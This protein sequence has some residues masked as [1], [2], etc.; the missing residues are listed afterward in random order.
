MHINAKTLIDRWERNISKHSVED[1][2]IHNH[3]HF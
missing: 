2:E 3:M 1:P